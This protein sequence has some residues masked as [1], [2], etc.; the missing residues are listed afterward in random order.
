MQ[1]VYLQRDMKKMRIPAKKNKP[2]TNPIP[3]NL[4]RKYPDKAARLAALWEKWYKSST[5]KKPG[6]K[7]NKK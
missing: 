6:E 2:K 5:S 3:P 4:K 7:K 1:S